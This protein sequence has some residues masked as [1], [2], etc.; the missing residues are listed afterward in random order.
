MMVLGVGSSRS[1]AA[2]LRIDV[3]AY[4][5]VLGM[6]VK[7]L[8]QGVAICVPTQ[9]NFSLYMVHMILEWL[10]KN[11]HMSPP[12]CR[13]SVS[14]DSTRGLSVSPNSTR[15]LLVPL[16]FPLEYCQQGDQPVAI[17]YHN[18]PLWGSWPTGM[19]IALFENH[20]NSYFI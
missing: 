2:S 20:K 14:P 16:A 7:D 6:V 9:L 1:H 3:L 13:L 19:R 18:L 12:T 11:F 15:G 5:K 4:G 17:Q 10:V 8:D